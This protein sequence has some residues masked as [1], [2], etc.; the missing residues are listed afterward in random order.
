MPK[1]TR[2]PD[3][4]AQNINEFSR[5]AQRYNFKALICLH[6]VLNYD[7]SSPQAIYDKIKTIASRQGIS[8]I[9]LLP[10]YRT[11]SADLRVFIAQEKDAFHPNRKGH[12][13]VARVLY[14]H[15]TDFLPI[16][17]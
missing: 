3:I 5:L 4:M 2:G 9:D 15:L 7:T 13:L 8:V 14:E 16:N 17:H 6:P 11:E 12:A 10:A 1:I